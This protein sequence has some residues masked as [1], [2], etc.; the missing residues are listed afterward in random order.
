MKIELIRHF[1]VDHKWKA[2]YTSDELK[3][4]CEK[5][6]NA[7]IINTSEIANRHGNVYISQL[8]RTNLTSK[9][10]V[11]KSNISIEPLLNEVSLNPFC[12]LNKK[13]PLL[14]WVLLW[15]TNWLFNIKAIDEVQNETKNRAELFLKKIEENGEDVTVVG[16]AN[17]FSVLLKLLKKR[18]YKG[19]YSAFPFRNGEMRVFQSD[20]REP[21]SM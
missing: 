12:V 9:F 14:I 15:K 2:F 17:Y 21:V 3:T 13:A 10:L 6:D 20:R 4:D 8:K 18:N 1:R 11:N 19:N 16:H 5:Y 7:E